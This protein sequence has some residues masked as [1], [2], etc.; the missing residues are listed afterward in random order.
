MRQLPSPQ[1][2]EKASE[3]SNVHCNFLHQLVGLAE[4]GVGSLEDSS[5]DQARHQNFEEEEQ[6][7]L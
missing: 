2:T 5:D 3:E 4:S 1:C 6:D 7:N